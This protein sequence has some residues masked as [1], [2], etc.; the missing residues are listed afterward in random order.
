VRIAA[1][2]KQI[3]AG[4]IGT[5]SDPPEGMVRSTEYIASILGPS[6]LAY[7]VALDEAVFDNTEDPAWYSM[8]QCDSRY[9]EPI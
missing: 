1:D 3:G 2:S 7:W 6:V 8:I 4:A 5:I 9:L